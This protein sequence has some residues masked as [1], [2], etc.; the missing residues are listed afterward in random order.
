MIRETILATG[1]WFFLKY[2]YN[3]LIIDNDN[4][5]YAISLTNALLMVGYSGSKLLLNDLNGEM[6]YD[7]KLILSILKG[8]FIYDSINVIKNKQYIY[9]VHHGLSLI[10]MNF[11]EKYN[12]KKLFI[13]SLFIGE[14]T[15]PLL[16]S[17][18]ISKKN[19]YKK[20]FSIINHIFTPTFVVMRGII[21][22]IQ[23]YKC[24]EYIYNEPH[25]SKFDLGLVI[26]LS[27][28]FNL[29]NYIWMNQL[30]R[31]YIK[32]LDL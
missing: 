19:G 5:H 18:K 32:W 21:M 31:G 11:F 13:Q 26:S 30:V 22:P 6:G 17:W 20:T 29:G 12:M 28:L 14:L 8:Y 16:N 2:I 10:F 24:I 23:F 9:I 1:G 3:K 27:C 4:R 25:V 15:N 7:Q